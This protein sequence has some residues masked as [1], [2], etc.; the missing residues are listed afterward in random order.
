M[1]NNFTNNNSSM[2]NETV[3]FEPCGICRDGMGVTDGAAL[4]EIPDSV[5]LLAEAGDIT[6]E[7]A[8]GFCLSGACSP[9]TCAA[10][11]QGISEPCGCKAM[12]ENSEP[13]GSAAMQ[14]CSI[15][16]GSTGSFSLTNPDVLISVPDELRQII[17]DSTEIKCS[18]AEE[19]C[20]TGFC[21]PETCT[22]FA[23]EGA[24]EA[25]GCVANEEGIE[26]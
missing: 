8:E 6:C 1:G 24:G 23:T 12:D 13:T 21:D 25:C 4:I 3:A 10:F 2:G 11:T 7:M 17:A 20:Q 18:V 14:Q 5:G 15:C 22:A 19:R 9:E 16:T 26:L